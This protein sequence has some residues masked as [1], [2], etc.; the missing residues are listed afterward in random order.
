MENKTRPFDLH[1][2]ICTNTRTPS[3]D[4][5]PVKQ[6]CGPLGGDLLRGELKE[7]LR[8]EIL[9]RPKLQGKFRARVNG[10]GCLDFCTKGIAMAIYP[11][12]EFL[13]SVQNT[14]TDREA[15][16]ALLTKKLDEAERDANL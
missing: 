1:V 11:E 10:S 5:K 8:N 4:G 7:W 6:S 3:A 13:L 15:I 14:E 12:G 2:M 16:K 9:S